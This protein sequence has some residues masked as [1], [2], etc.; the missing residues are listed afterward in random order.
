MWQVNWTHLSTY[1][2]VNISFKFTSLG[3]SAGHSSLNWPRGSSS[4]TQVKWHDSK[5][6]FLQGLTVV[7]PAGVEDPQRQDP[8][9]RHATLADIWQPALCIMPSFTPRFVSLWDSA[10]KS[11]GGQHPQEGGLDHLDL[12]RFPKAVSHTP[13]G[14]GASY[15]LILFSRKPQEERQHCIGCL[16]GESQAHH[17]GDLRASVA[18]SAP[19]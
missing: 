7:Q 12:G 16:Q 2:E 11:Y 10:W 19:A 13:G 15:Q 14:Q 6:L 5:A 4:D 3:H 8:M 9:L 18:W 1:S 17:R